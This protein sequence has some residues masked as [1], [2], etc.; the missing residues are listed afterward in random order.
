MT[1]G[2]GDGGGRLAFIRYAV[3]G[4]IAFVV[5]LVITLAIARYWHYLVANTIGFVAAN[6]LQFFIVH[7]WVFRR[8]LTFDAF[9]R[10]YPATLSISLLGL[11]CSNLL[12]FV[13]VDVM[14]LSLV[15]A[16]A[17][18]ALIVLCIN[19]SLRVL[20]LYGPVRSGP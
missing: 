3:T 7:L 13:G 10:L 5:D 17:G 19:Y 14:G 20:F 9:V 12:L 6:L 2:R 18:T 8:T 4:V 16:K 1:G 15:I 11:V